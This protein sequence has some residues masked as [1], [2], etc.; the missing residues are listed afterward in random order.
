MNLN[1]STHINDIVQVFEYQDLYDVVLVGHSYGGMVIGGVAEK[2]PD[3]I[4]SMVFLDAYIPQDGK[5]GFDLIPG[6][7]DIYEQRRLKEEGKNWLVLSYTPEEFGVTNN[8]DINW[9][10]SRL[11]PMPLHTH[12]E[13]LSIKEIK[14]KRLSRTYITCT[15]F[16]DSMFHSIKSKESDGW[17]Y[18]ELRP[19]HDSMITAPEELSGL[20]LKIINNND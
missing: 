9:M 14:P 2:I 20:L 11:C 1:L 16:G 6:L 10:K 17:D 3:R 12:D 15:D 8:D 5:S 4:R 19:G 7:R 13:P 18:F